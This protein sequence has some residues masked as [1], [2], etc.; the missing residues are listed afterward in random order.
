MSPLAPVPQDLNVDE[1]ETG[2]AAE[3][4]FNLA[5]YVGM[6]ERGETLR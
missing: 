1:P 2:S 5:E 6:L 4:E 3:S